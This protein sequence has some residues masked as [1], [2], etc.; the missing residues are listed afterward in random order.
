MWRE[1]FVHSTGSTGGFLKRPRH[2]AVQYQPGSEMPEQFGRRGGSRARIRPE[3]LARWSRPHVVITHT[4]EEDHED[5]RHVRLSD[6]FACAMATPAFASEQKI[7][8]MLG[9]KF[10]RPISAMGKR[11]WRTFWCEGWDLKSMKA[12]LVTIDGE[13]VKAGQLAAAVNGSRRGWHVRQAMK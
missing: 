11:R 12:C 10:A 13:K 6:R 4:L 9:G 5:I 3:L 1:R 2:S 7:T 8:L